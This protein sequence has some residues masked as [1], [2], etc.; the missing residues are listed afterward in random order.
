MDYVNNLIYDLVGKYNFFRVIYSF[1]NHST[2]VLLGIQ[3]QKSMF[4]ARVLRSPVYHNNNNN[5]EQHLNRLTGTVQEAQGTAAAFENGLVESEG[6]FIGICRWSTR[7]TYYYIPIID[8][9]HLKE[10]YVFICVYAVVCSTQR[11]HLITR[12]ASRVFVSSE[13]FI[14]P[15]GL[16]ERRHMRI[17]VFESQ[18]EHKCYGIIVRVYLLQRPKNGFGYVNTNEW[19]YIM[20]ICFRNNILVL[21]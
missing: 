20:W 5:N 19:I 4:Y 6:G 17:I 3:V 21:R 16:G 15:Y 18:P 2:V 9:R 8:I 7:C 10:T 1:S 12:I 14:T 13:Q 11:V